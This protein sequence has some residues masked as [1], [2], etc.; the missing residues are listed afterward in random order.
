MPSHTHQH[1]GNSPNFEN[2]FVSGSLV[3]AVSFYWHTNALERVLG[4]S[5]ICQQI[6]SSV[7]ITRTSPRAN[8]SQWQQ[9]FQFCKQPSTRWISK[10]IFIA[11]IGHKKNFRALHTKRSVS[12]CCAW[13]VLAFGE[14]QMT[15]D[16]FSCHSNC[17]SMK[18]AQPWCGKTFRSMLPSTFKGI[19]RFVQEAS[20]LFRIAQLAYIFHQLGITW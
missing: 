4:V 14:M 6:A 16:T 9:K 1:I 3:L 5:D 20:E 2:K 18:R 13:A 12:V 10:H 11:L 15:D 19:A 17:F 7:E 8:S